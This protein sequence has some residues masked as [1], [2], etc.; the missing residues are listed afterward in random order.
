MQKY[1]YTQEEK[2]FLKFQPFL[3]GRVL[4]VGN[5]L[6]YLAS[7][8]DK[9][10]PHLTIIDIQKNERAENK[11]KIIIYD[12]QHFPF[13]N[14]SFDSVVCTY[15]LHHTPYPLEVFSEMKRVA[16]RI[17]IIEE[18]Y[19]SIFAKID[20]IYRDIYVNVLAGQPSKIYW[21]SYFKKGDLEKLFVKN[22][23]SVIN[24]QE[25][26]KRT[27]WKELFILE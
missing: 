5:G 25:E 9:T 12:G 11:N 2:W 15:V 7:F 20:L 17:I 6:G 26:R 13:E 23:L 27:Y 22:N 19:S 8:I 18:T 24:H 4:K 10:N 21:K 14:Q 16:K 3:K 1:I